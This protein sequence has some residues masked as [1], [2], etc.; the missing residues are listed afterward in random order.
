M[1]IMNFKGAAFCISLLAVLPIEKAS[2]ELAISQLIVELKPGAS[3]AADIEV[4]NDSAKRTF[5]A[6][7]PREIIDAG[8][9]QEKPLFSPDPDQLGLL[10]SPTRLVIEPNQRRRLRI[11][12]I[13]PVPGKERIYRVTIKPVAGEI[14]GPE[15]GLK[16]LI[17]YDML[18]LVRP[19]IDKPNVDFSRAG[20]ALT[21]VNRGN[22]SVE[23][24]EGK[25]CDGNG[26]NCLP[27]PSKRLYAGASW[28]QSLSLPAAGEYRI[29]SG[30][31]WSTIK[32]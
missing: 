30:D 5:V 19:P 23:L 32:F 16:M 2:A 24:A 4:Y 25:Q 6:I 12:A 26:R 13:A 27:L 11:A 1:S 20:G 14:T 31:S 15:S 17:G 28:R 22:A 9:A 7:E 21:I 10:V 29:R 3:R 18:V 8:T